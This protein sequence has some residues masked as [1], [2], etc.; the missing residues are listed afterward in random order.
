MP[1]LL[2]LKLL[3]HIIISII[4]IVTMMYGFKVTNSCML[5]F[6]IFLHNISMDIKPTNHP[7]DGQTGSYGSFKE[8]SLGSS[9]DKLILPF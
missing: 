2:L 5:V 3:L 7:T 6:A 1:L 8:S 4:I 9:E